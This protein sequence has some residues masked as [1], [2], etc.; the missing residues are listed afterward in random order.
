MIYAV[1]Y[2]GISAYRMKEILQEIKIEVLYDCRS[3]PHSRYDR[4]FDTG[5]LSGILEPEVGYQWVGKHLGG[6]GAPITPRAIARLNELGQEKIIC[7][8]CSEKDYHKCHRHYAIAKM[9]KEQCGTTVNHVVHSN[10]GLNY[11]IEPARFE[12]EEKSQGTL[13]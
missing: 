8:M 10:N 3:N 5:N 13:F 7:V 4:S 12:E 2:G 9:L 1:G 11:F 6:L